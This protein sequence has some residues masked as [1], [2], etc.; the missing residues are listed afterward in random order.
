MNSLLGGE[1]LPRRGGERGLFFNGRSCWMAFVYLF[2]NCP[3]VGPWFADLPCTFGLLVFQVPTSRRFGLKVRCCS[4]GRFDRSMAPIRP[5]APGQQTGRAWTT[6]WLEG[7]SCPSGLGVL[8]MILKVGFPS[9]VYSATTSLA[10]IL[11][12][13]FIGL[14][15]PITTFFPWAPSACSGRRRTFGLFSYKVWTGKGVLSTCISESTNRLSSTADWICRRKILQSLVAWEKE[16]CHLQYA[17]L[18]S[19][20][21]GG[22]AWDKWMFPCLSNSSKFYHT[23]KHQ[24]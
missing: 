18:F 22:I 6:G 1:A 16:L 17:C 2:N 3:K 11:S 20:S 9:G 21:G 7:F 5:V 4:L 12:F 14:G 8:T 15:S 13:A 19:S 24:K 10:R 23:W